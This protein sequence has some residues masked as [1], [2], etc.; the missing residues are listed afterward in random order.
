[1]VSG[2]RWKFRVSLLAPGHFHHLAPHE[3]DLRRE[4][5]ILR[6]HVV[7]GEQRHAAEDAVVVADDLVVVGVGARVARVEPEAR[8]PVQ[9]D[10]ARRNPRACAPCRTPRR[11]SR[12]RCSGRARRSCRRGRDPS[13]PRSARGRDPGPSGA[14]SLRGARSCRASTCRCS[15]DRSPISSKNGSGASVISAAEV[16]GQRAAR[17]RRPAVDHHRAAAADAGAADEVE[18]QRRVHASRGSRSA[19]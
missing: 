7:A 1:M 5:Q 2:R 18:L 4:R 3:R 14:A 17:E 8:D 12:T 6:A 9:A 15:T 11:S 13:A 10:G 16:L 19:R